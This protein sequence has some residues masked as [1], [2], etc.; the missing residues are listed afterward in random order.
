MLGRSYL[1]NTDYVLRIQ[2]GRQLLTFRW[3]NSEQRRRF[4]L[5]HPQGRYRNWSIFLK[6]GRI[7]SFRTHAIFFRTLANIMGTHWQRNMYFCNRKGAVD[8][9][10]KSH[11]SKQ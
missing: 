1:V 9:V 6:N 4:A 3:T 7:M 5:R 2:P 10:N 11:A 8:T